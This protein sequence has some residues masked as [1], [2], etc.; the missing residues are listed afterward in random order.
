MDWLARVGGEE[1]LRHLGPIGT[2]FILGI[3]PDL[4]PRLLEAEIS[5]FS[6]DALREGLGAVTALRSQLGGGLVH[7]RGGLL[8]LFE[9]GGPKFRHPGKTLQLLP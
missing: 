9:G 5:E 6:D 4:E 2:R 3:E 8:E 7:L 1:E